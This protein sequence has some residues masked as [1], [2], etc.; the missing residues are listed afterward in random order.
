[1]NRRSAIWRLYLADAASVLL[2][3]NSAKNFNLVLVGQTLCPSLFERVGEEWEESTPSW[4]YL[5]RTGMPRRNDV[6][7]ELPA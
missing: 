1:M 3:A 4:Y 7:R 5:R 2:F 6:T